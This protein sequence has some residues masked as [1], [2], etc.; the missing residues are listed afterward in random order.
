MCISR[1]LRILFAA[2]IFVVSSHASANT[3]Y[4]LEITCSKEPGV[5]YNRQFWA[6]DDAD[7]QNKARA[8]ISSAEFQSKGGCSIKNL[9][10]G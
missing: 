5:T 9:K 1:I 10:K 6:K 7:A 2:F 3:S 4:M 8:I